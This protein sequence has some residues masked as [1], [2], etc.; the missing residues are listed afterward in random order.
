MSSVP[1]LAEFLA[2][3]LAEVA[4]VCPKTVFFA[5]GG[6]RRAARLAG[7]S[8]ADE[9]YA[10]WSRE[11][12][13]EATALLFRLGVQHLFF[14]VL[15]PAQLAERGYYRERLIDWIAWGLAGPETLACYQ[16]HGW[17]ARLAGAESL[18]ALQSV[19]QQLSESTPQQAEHTIWWYA[20]A[21]PDEHWAMLLRAAQRAQA[22][23]Q[24]ELIRA[25]YG[26]DLPPATLCL[27]FG[28][29]M[30]AADM[31]PLV[32]AGELQCYW[33]QQPGFQ[34]DERMVRGVIYDLAFRRQTWRADKHQR[35]D[36]VLAYRQAWE[37]AVVLG[38]GTKLGA[39]WYPQ[40]FAAPGVTPDDPEAGP[41][42][43]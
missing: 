11:R 3:P 7:I 21:T 16:Q 24:A 4:A 43:G 20:S 23:S 6:T 1:S 22:Q 26:E 40:P 29:P 37:Q 2:A 10:H 25:M 12:M 35:A 19:A 32:V 39:F 15:R 9:R 34:M 33:Y 41:P 28:K 42:G 5:P 14:N 30:I 17:R 36:D 27:S 18:P 13:L 31:L 8:S 38:L